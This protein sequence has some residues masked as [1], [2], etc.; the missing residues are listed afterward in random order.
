MMNN[1][2]VIGVI[3]GQFTVIKMVLGQLGEL[4]QKQ[5]KTKGVFITGTDTDVGKS[6]IAGGLAGALHA[7][8]VNVGVMK[9]VQSGALKKDGKLV[10]LD[11]QFMLRASGIDDELE[12]VNPVRFHLPAA[13]NLAAKVADCEINLKYLIKRYKELQ[14]RHEFIIV[15]GAGGLTTPITDDCQMHE[16]IK[17]LGLPIIIVA[18]PGLGTINH[19]LL[20]AEFARQNDIP[21]VGVIINNYPQGDK[22]FD[23][24]LRT[25]PHQIAR[26]GTVNILGIVPHDPTLSLEDCVPGNIVKIVENNVELDFI[27]NFEMGLND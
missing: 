8:G 14:K 16:F 17:A 10:S 13:P 21:I 19:T 24:V 18:R 25:N 2:I 11:A 6:V 20:T 27:L 26:F 15:E 5:N 12:M 1:N 7:R 3:N 4:G 22:E 9:P 23:I